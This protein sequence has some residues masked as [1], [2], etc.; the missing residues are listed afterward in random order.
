[1]LL[2]RTEMLPEGA[3]WQYEIKFDGY[4][5]LAIK[6]GGKVQLRSRAQGRAGPAANGWGDVLRPVQ[7]NVVDEEVP[8]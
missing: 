6:T 5:A 3:D 4:R 8:R 1:M 2:L 7:T